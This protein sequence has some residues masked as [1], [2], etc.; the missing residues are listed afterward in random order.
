[1]MRTTLSGHLSFQRAAAT[2]SG[3]P[4]TKAMVMVASTSSKVAANVSRMSSLTG[5]FG[6]QRAAEIALRR[7]PA[8]NRPYCSIERPVE[9]E[10]AVE[11]GHLFRRGA[12]ARAPAAPGRRACRGRWRRSTIDRPD[13]DQDRPQHAPAKEREGNSNAGRSSVRGQSR[14]DEVLSWRERC[15]AGRRGERGPALPRPVPGSGDRGETHLQVQ[16]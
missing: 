1:M 11:V 5:P 3:T 2:P 12:R 4:S 13:K 9:A 10:L 8:T 7:A 16:L 14:P 6:Q 15:R